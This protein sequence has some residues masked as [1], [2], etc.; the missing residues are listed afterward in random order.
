MF[1]ISHKIRA[2]ERESGYNTT[3]ILFIFITKLYSYIKH[4][5]KI[6]RIRFLFSNKAASSAAGWRW[7]TLFPKL[8]IQARVRIR[9][10]YSSTRFTHERLTIRTSE[11]RIPHRS[12][13]TRQ[14][15]RIWS[16]GHKIIQEWFRPKVF[17][18]RGQPHSPA[19]RR[20]Q[21]AG[22]NPWLKP[23]DPTGRSRTWTGF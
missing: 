13:S 18:T 3:A 5:Q 16:Y 17:Y 2:R 4:S 15:A 6:C 14:G 22:A 12:A 23:L 8:E 10:L 21:S 19:R 11:M 20:E 7:R 1:L 9:Q